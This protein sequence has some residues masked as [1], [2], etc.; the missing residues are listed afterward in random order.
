MLLSS[1]KKELEGQAGQ[2]LLPEEGTHRWHGKGPS[3]GGD[4]GGAEE[5]LSNLPE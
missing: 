2:V 1:R 3:K 4:K 5:S